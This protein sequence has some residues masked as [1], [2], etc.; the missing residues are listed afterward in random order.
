M[1]PSQSSSKKRLAIAT[2][3]GTYFLCL[4]EIVQLKASNN[5]TNIY[6]ANKKVI[7]TS[8]VLK[9]YVQLLEPLGFVRTHRKHLVNRQHINYINRQGNI[10]MNDASVAEISR[11]MKN[12]VM[13][14][15][16][17]VL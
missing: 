6:L 4:E 5:Y 1:I 2:N 7:L 13:K 11:R 17:N 14:V 3:N 15:L 10:I 16:M 12:G 8:K 9:K